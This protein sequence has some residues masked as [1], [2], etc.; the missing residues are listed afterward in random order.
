M[1]KWITLLALLLALTLAACAPRDT[2]SPTEETTPPTTEATEPPTTQATE[3]ASQIRVG[4]YLLAE[5]YEDGETVRGEEVD[6]LQYYLLVREDNTGTISMMGMAFEMEWNESQ[7]I[8]DG[9]PTTYTMDG[10]DL[11]LDMDKFSRFTF[12]FN[13]DV[14]PESYR[15]TLPPTGFYVVSSIS[16]S[17]NITFY[18]A[19]DPENGYLELYEGS[20]TGCLYLDGEEQDITWDRDYIYAGEEAIPYFYQSAESIGDTDGLLMLYF[21]DR[22]TSVAL[23]PVEKPEE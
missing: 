7:I 15:S 3:P 18:G 17:G 16:V 4:Y 1:R 2:P 12:R 14:L 6:A 11:I 9:I 20:E 13:G 8:V 10:D 23:R 19:P 5:V 21:P 22:E